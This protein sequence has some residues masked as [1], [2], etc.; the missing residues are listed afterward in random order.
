MQLLLVGASG[1]SQL[2]YGC[3]QHLASLLCRLTHV[4][5][6][7]YAAGPAQEPSY[8]FNECR[9]LLAPPLR[10]LTTLTK[11][12][13]SYGADC[14]GHSYFD[15]VSAELHKPQPIRTYGTQLTQWPGHIQGVLELPA[16]INFRQGPRYNG[17]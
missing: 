2:P 11:C 10:G 12:S 1:V 4:T 6:A 7:L 5:P 13:L 17:R 9:V 16:D 15:G 3:I 8:G 14:P